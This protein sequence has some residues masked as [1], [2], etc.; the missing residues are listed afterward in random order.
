VSSAD[1]EKL[2]IAEYSKFHTRRLN[3]PEQIE[4]DDSIIDDLNDVTKSKNSK[5]R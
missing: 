4:T 3:A 5:T 2:A 1:M